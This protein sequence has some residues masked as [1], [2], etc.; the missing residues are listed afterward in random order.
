MTNEPE[1]TTLKERKVPEVILVSEHTS[2]QSITH[3]SDHYTLFSATLFLLHILLYI[4]FT[5]N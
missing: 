5:V 3:G 2:Q 4:F 1:H